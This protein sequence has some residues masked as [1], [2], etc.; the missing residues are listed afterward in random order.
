MKLSRRITLIVLILGLLFFLA[1]LFRSFIL[2]NFVRPVSLMFWMGLRVLQSI[3]QNIIWGLVLFFAVI[4]LLLRLGREPAAF[5]S[6]R[7]P[8]PNTTLENVNYWR[9]AILV[10]HDEITE[11]NVLKRYLGKMLAAVYAAK[12][13][14][15]AN[16]EIYN[17]LKQGDILLPEP[18][19][20]F[21][22]PAAPP[23]AGRSFRRVL[24]SIRDFPRKWSR[25]WSGRDVEEYYASIEEVLT[26]VE[27]TLEIKHDDTESNS[28]IH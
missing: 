18:V 28:H 11:L 6:N 1:V 17:A 27:S 2:D 23:A 26:Y 9:T 19:Y 12:Q 15:S 4:F 16:L 10:T 8:A 20:A 14:G 25:R 13:P 24:A 3:D 22:F 5:E 7:P 21:L